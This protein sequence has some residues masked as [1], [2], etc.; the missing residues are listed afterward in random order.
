MGTSLLGD[1]GATVIKV[2]SFPR[3]PT[4]RIIGGPA[5]RGFTNND[6]TGPRPW[7]RAAIHNMANRNKYGVTL[8]LAHRRGL[9][10]FERLVAITDVVCE[11]YTA[12]TLD[13]LGV[14]YERMK[15]LKPDIIMVSMPGWGVR[16]PYKGYVSLGSGIDG[17]TGHHAL[18]GYPG[19]D[20]TVTPVAQHADAVGAVTLTFAVLAALY[21]RNRT[22]EG[23]WV[24]V[25]QVEAFLP[26]LSRP[27]MDHVMNGR[28]FAPA[29][30]RDGHMAPHG[31]YPCS[32]DDGWVA[33]A[34]SSDSQWRALVRAM[35]DP[36][37]AR[38]PAFSDALSRHRSQD[39]LDRHVREWTGTRDKKTVMSMLQEAGV[40]AQAVLDDEDLY[41]DPHLAARGFFQRVQHPVIGDHRYPGYLWNLGESSPAVDIPPATYGEHNRYVYGDLLGMSDEEIDDLE[42][43][44][45]I[46]DEVAQV[47]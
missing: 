35:G 26:H 40:P 3:V 17:F 2:E 13:R 46:G 31:C 22:G 30:N 42:A 37:W 47:L 27:F 9:D 34:V 38:D 14:S 15:E 43:Q 4:T 1:L 6:P 11:A 25:S 20:P 39:L 8:N 10:V 18:R 16:G 12:G 33:I 41:A 28:G 44:G 21:H 36:D 32:G 7:D 45:V 24:D 29:G 19:T 23:Q 5:A